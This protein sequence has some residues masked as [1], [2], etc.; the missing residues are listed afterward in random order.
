M[1]RVVAF[2]DIDGT[3]YREGLITELF[4]KITRYELVDKEVW[5]DA[6]EPAYLKWS[7][8]EGDYD[9]YLLSM[10]GVF[11]EAVIGIS[12][13][14][15]KHVAHRVIEQRG[16]RVYAFTRD[17]IK[18]HRKQGHLVIAISGSPMELVSKMA[19]KYQMDDFRATIYQVDAEGCYTGEIIPMWD[20]ES[21]QKAL[22][23]LKEE[24]EIDLAQSYAYGDTTGDLTMFKAVGHPYAINPT[25]ELLNIILADPALKEKL[26]VIVERKDV[27]YLMNLDHTELF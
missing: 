21:K 2:F 16:D 27:R 4:K 6:V 12:S 18:W 14:H 17:R 22:L 25:K 10:V 23:E 1:S 24:Y 15:I 11:L 7:R 26:N 20:A 19:E 5:R 3:L 13:E 8:R 9:E